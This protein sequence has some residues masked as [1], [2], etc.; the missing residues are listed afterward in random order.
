MLQVDLNSA[1][2][3]LIDYL[4]KKFEGQ[5][6]EAK[7]I[8]EHYFKHQINELSQLGFCGPNGIIDL[9]DLPD[10]LNKTNQLYEELLDSPKSTE[11][12]NVLTCLSQVHTLDIDERLFLENSVNKFIN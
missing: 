12:V 1:E 2:T 5:A 10:I 6:L 9:N 4:C 8:N 7:T 3:T 11:K